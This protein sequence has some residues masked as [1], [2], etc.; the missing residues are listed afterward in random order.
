MLIY[1]LLFPVL[2]MVTIAVYLIYFIN[3]HRCINLHLIRINLL[4]TTVRPDFPITWTPIGICVETAEADFSHQNL[5]DF[6]NKITL[7]QVNV[8]VINISELVEQ[9]VI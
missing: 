1:L 4:Q 7:P 6:V 8:S 5:A 9:V 3:D 2:E